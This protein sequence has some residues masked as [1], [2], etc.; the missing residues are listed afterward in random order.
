MCSK[1]ALN[2]IWLRAIPVVT[3]IFKQD[4][5]YFQNTTPRVSNFSF[6]LCVQPSSVIKN[7]DGEVKRHEGSPTRSWG[8][9]GPLH[10]QFTNIY[11]QACIAI[12]LRSIWLRPISPKCLIVLLP[13]CCS[14][15]QFLDKDRNGHH[16]IALLNFTLLFVSIFFYYLYPVRFS[17]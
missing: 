16:W 5:K 2:S 4:S 8:L 9:E 14:W 12:A 15:W 7:P 10:F 1:I 3:N 13:P 17:T 11:N 6:V